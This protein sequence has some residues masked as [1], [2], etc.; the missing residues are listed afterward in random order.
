LKDLD[1]GFELRSVEL[2]ADH[3]TRVTG[4]GAEYHKKLPGLF[5]TPGIEF[6]DQTVQK[7]Q[8]AQGEQFDRQKVIAQM[9]ELNEK[10]KL[11]NIEYRKIRDKK[12]ITRREEKKAILAN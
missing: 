10:T 2:K 5:M 1:T 4:A 3:S 11:I 12:R 9:A 7:L 6:T 8:A